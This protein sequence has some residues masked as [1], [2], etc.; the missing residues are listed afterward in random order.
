M[1]VEKAVV[2]GA[3]GVD[4]GGI[5]GALDFCHA[6]DKLGMGEEG[7]E[8]LLDLGEGEV[9]FLPA[10]MLFE[11]TERSDGRAM[12]I[13][14]L[15]HDR[16]KTAFPGVALMERLF[17]V[18]S[19]GG[20]RGSFTCEK[21]VEIIAEVED[22]NIAVV[23]GG[24]GVGNAGVVGGGGIAAGRV[25]KGL[26]V[27]EVYNV[28][29]VSLV[30]VLVEKI[31][32]LGLLVADK[33]RDSDEGADVGERI[34]GVL[35]DDAILLR[36]KFK[37]VGCAAFGSDRPSDS[38]RAEGASEADDVEEVPATATVFPLPF[39]G[40]V[41]VAP[42]GMTDKLVVEADGVIADDGRRGS[43]DLCEEKFTEF[44]L[45][46]TVLFGRLR[47]DAGDHDGA[48]ARKGVVVESDEDVVRLANRV[49]IKVGEI[50][51]AHV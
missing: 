33:L 45:G 17:E 10:T 43:G 7:F 39:V 31:E 27:I 8:I 20:F 2:E 46:K 30:A 41:E 50:G 4:G 40:V 5:V 22:E 24:E 19:A 35:M 48:G 32:K 25:D 23:G 49:K 34:V 38:L 3:L 15:F 44:A 6:F 51:R 18:E 11:D 37:A 42:E 21:L 26:G 9:D 36:N 16:L 29:D 1:I 14:E 28:G 47:G 13:L 12:I